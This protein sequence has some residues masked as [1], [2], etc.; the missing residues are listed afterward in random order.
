M[1]LDVFRP[2][3]SQDSGTY[4]VRNSFSRSGLIRSDTFLPLFNGSRQL[5]HLHCSRIEN[6]T[7]QC[8]F[9]SHCLRVKPYHEFPPSCQACASCSVVLHD[10]QR[11]SFQK[12]CQCNVDLR[13][14]STESRAASTSSTVNIGVS[15]WAAQSVVSLSRS[16][17]SLPIELATHSLSLSFPLSLSLSYFPLTGRTV[18]IFT[19]VTT[20]QETSCSLPSDKQTTKISPNIRCHDH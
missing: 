15:C 17:T 6:A 4:I 18:T 7:Q 3:F 8:P 12:L 1:C 11:L 19:I 20:D 13:I 10:V 2:H 9:P 5:M 16:P 14:V